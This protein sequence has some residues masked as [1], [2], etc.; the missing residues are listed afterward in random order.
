[1]RRQS[2]HRISGAPAYGDASLELRDEGDSM[3]DERR[4]VSDAWRERF[5]KLVGCSI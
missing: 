1:M 4:R 5:I 3:N 2:Q